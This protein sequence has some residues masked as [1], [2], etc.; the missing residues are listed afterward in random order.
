MPAMAKAAVRALDATSEFLYRK[1][2]NY[3]FNVGLIGKQNFEK[4]FLFSFII[5]MKFKVLQK[6]PGLPGLWPQL[7]MRGSISLR[8]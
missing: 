5:K 8:L 7:T 4:N 3:P 2:G 1:T 6:G